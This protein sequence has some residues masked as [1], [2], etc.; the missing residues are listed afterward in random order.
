MLK[1]SIIVVPSEGF[2]EVACADE[3]TIEVEVVSATGAKCTSM[4]GKIK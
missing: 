2:E 3:G 1:A 4:F